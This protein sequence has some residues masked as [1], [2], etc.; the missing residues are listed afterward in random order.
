MVSLNYSNAHLLIVGGTGFI[1][2]WVV[3]AGLEY[4]YTVSVL[5]L[6]TPNLS[7]RIDGVEYFVADL[8]DK[9]SVAIALREK[10]FSHVINLG[11][12]INHCQFKDGGRDIIDVHFIGVLNL[13][14][15]LNWDYLES[16]IQIGSSDEY[17]NTS[18]PQSEDQIVSPISCYS[19][20]KLA[21]GQFLQML[22]RTEGFPAIILR[23]F[24]VYGPGQGDNRF[25]PQMILGCLNDQEFPVSLGEQI[26]DFCYIVDIVEGIFLAL[27]SN[28]SFG[29]VINL[30]SG[31]PTSIRSVVEKVNNLIGYGKPKFGEIDYRPGENMSLF[32]DIQKAR[33][34]LQ[35]SPKID[36]DKGLKKT[37]SKY[38]MKR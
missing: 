21:S 5:S 17:G 15:S 30:A 27:T 3:K 7:K 11:G 2:R 37:I 26:R 34:C 35:W 32:A 23:L 16:F 22:S 29:E 31:S 14:D 33:E 25:L 6:N 28:N 38:A 19:V 4:G 1:G 24:L 36:L 13:V 8:L 20:G 9:E 10:K 12:F 18:S